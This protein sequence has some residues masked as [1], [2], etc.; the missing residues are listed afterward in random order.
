MLI[1]LPHDQAPAASAHQA[2][3]RL[4]LAGASTRAAAG[5]ALRAN[6]VPVCADLFADVDLCRFARTLPIEATSYPRGLVD[7]A[8]AAPDGPW[9][10]TGALENHP[11]IVEQISRHRRLWGTSA[12][13]LRR[14]R[15]PWKL[16]A[17]LARHGLPHLRIW[18]Q[19]STT[20][21][22]DGTWMSKPCRGSGGR[23]IMPWHAGQEIEGPLHH[24]ICF[25]E[26]RSGLPVSGLFLA[27][28][29]TTV[30]IGV[31]RQL[32]G[33]HQVHAAP[34][35]YCGSIAPLRLPEPVERLVG[36]IGRAVAS[37][38]DLQG[39]FGC[40][41]LVDSA[42]PWLTEV[43]PRYTASVEVL[44]HV[45]QIPLLD[46]HRRAC[47]EFLTGLTRT[48]EWDAFA[49]Q[50]TGILAC[51][52]QRRV[53]KVIVYADRALQAGDWTRFISNPESDSIPYMADIPSPGQSID[54]GQPICTIFATASGAAECLRRLLRRAERFYQTGLRAP[55]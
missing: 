43:N 22:R 18:P 19:D 2:K 8:Q 33:L 12:D 21:A 24:D 44:E 46:W 13:S 14:V 47:E 32:I 6:M 36:K 48:R 53:G 25:Q 51:K 1:P 27:R 55:R 30:L 34:Y 17:A 4:L 10:Y 52:A 37:D 3:T 45:L 23:G 16:A 11:A 15:S 39:L 42:G 38:F 54:A 41:F 31:T 49:T 20:P 40:D 9:M 35:A 5:S 50:L 29:G 26:R 7:L 28:P